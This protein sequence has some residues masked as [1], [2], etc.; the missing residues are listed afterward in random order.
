VCDLPIE[1]AS[2]AGVLLMDRLIAINVKDTTGA[3]L[4]KSNIRIAIDGEPI[5][6]AIASNGHAAIQIP[7][8]AC[9]VEIEVEYDG[10]PI[11]RAVLAAD[12]CDRDFVFN[13]RGGF[14][15][16]RFWTQFLQAAV[17]VV[18]ILLVVGLFLYIGNISGLL[19]PMMG[20]VLVICALALAFVK[21]DLTSLQAQLVRSLFA[22]GAGGLATQIPGL[23]DLK[24]NFAT[25]A[26]ITASGAVAV[27]LVTFFWSPARDRD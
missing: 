1:A 23:L 2:G 13:V 10:L 6:E 4:P 27:Y 3:P 17:A 26:V 18:A 22:L 19:P 7:G 16:P 25:K 24:I 15:S 9:P 11:Q 21:R 20:G 8:P 5:A 14:A 12:Q